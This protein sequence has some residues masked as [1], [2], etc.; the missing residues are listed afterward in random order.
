VGDEPTPPRWGHLNVV[1]D[2]LIGAADPTFN[3]EAEK[4]AK[5]VAR[6][7][8]LSDSDLYSASRYLI[9]LNRHTGKLLWTASARLAF[10]HNT[11]CAG[12]G[13]LFAID[14]LSGP[15]LA[16]LSSEGEIPAVPRVVAFDLATGKEIWHDEEATFGTWLSYCEKFDVLIEAGRVA[17]DTLSDEPKGMRAYK[18]IDGKELWFDKA[19]TGPAM[20]HGD[21][22]LR[23]QGACDLLTGKP[24]MR[25]DP[26]TGELEEW[27]WSRN[28]GCNTPAASEHLLTFRS[29]AAGF[30]DLCHDGG[31]GNFGGFR[32]SC[33]NNLIVADGILAAPDYTRTCTCSYQNQCSIA[34][35]PMADAEEW[36]FYG[37]AGVKKIVQ[38]VGI[39]FGAP[40]DRKAAD[41]TLWLEY[42]GVGGAS[43][44]VQ[45][46][47]TGSKLAYFRHHQSSVTGDMPWVGCCGV[48]GVESVSI[49]LLPQELPDRYYT[50]RLHFAEPDD[51]REGER[52]FEV[53]LQGRHALDH[54]DVVKEAGK[55]HKTIIKEFRH[56]LVDDELR[57]SFHADGKRPAI[58]CGVEVV[59]E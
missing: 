20:L 40:G 9:V 37:K 58:I 48:T 3:T 57:I 30:F 23:G 2:Y 25:R 29:G 36:T 16:R 8:R 17:R 21:T 10:R 45:V 41:G 11:L 43:P 22:I 5:S 31:T 49:S 18:G 1:G 24:R 7:F 39:N 42:P 35:V 27:V 13:K 51:L 47:V 26:I 54:F 55:P 6:L 14:R 56:V 46:H 38:R 34:M 50:V 4:Q 33:T 52:V 28:Y 59:Q 12:N 32:S 44:A 19:A 15:R 53:T